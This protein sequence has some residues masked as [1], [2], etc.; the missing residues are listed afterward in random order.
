[1]MKPYKVCQNCGKEGKSDC[2]MLTQNRQTY[3]DQMSAEWAVRNMPNFSFGCIFQV[4]K[5]FW[6]MFR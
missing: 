1:M 6:N 2:D 5:T 4:G 3:S